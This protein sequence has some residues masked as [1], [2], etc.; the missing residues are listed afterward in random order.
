MVRISNSTYHSVGCLNKSWCVPTWRWCQVLT[1][2]CLHST[3][4]L[5]SAG[6][7]HCGSGPLSS[8]SSRMLQSPLQLS[9]PNWDHG[10]VSDKLK[11]GPLVRKL[12]LRKIE[13]RNGKCSIW[14]GRLKIQGKSSMWIGVI[15]ECFEEVWLRHLTQPYSPTS[16]LLALAHPTMSDLSSLSLGPS[17]ASLGSCSWRPQCCFPI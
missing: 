11:A 7:S 4:S 12:K 2:A 17:S 16:P 15:Q 8:S 14:W 1:P 6:H 13:K 10:R 5:D 9:V 3:P